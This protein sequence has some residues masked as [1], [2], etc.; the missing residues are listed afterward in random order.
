MGESRDW[1]V[2]LIVTTEHQ[3]TVKARSSEEAEDEAEQRFDEGDD[4]HITAVYTDQVI[5]VS[6]EQSDEEEFDETDIIQ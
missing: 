4:G 3:Y 6:G 2:S 1:L 5:A